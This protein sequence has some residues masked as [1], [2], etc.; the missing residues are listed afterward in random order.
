MVIYCHI[1][2]TIIIDTYSDLLEIIQS[3]L[4]TYIFS[5]NQQYTTGTVI[6]KDKKNNRENEQKLTYSFNNSQ[7]SWFLVNMY[8]FVVYF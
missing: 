2:N 6:L 3:K 5:Y 7:F 4:N 1:N 8:W